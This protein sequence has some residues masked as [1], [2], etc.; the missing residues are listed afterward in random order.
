MSVS[1]IVALLVCGVILVGGVAT[2]VRYLQRK[3]NPS[4]SPR[5]ALLAAA[6]ALLALVAAYLLVTA[7][8]LR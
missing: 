5:I 1:R 4:A 8:S 7:S 3:S 6:L 2:V